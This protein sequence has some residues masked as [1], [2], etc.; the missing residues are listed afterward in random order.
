MLSG[1]VGRSDGD[2]GEV[3]SL[4]DYHRNTVARRARAGGA[5]TSRDINIVPVINHW[6]DE[7]N[8]THLGLNLSR[9]LTDC[10]GEA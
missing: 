9:R 6:S 5:L 10:L 3:C 1:N 2:G 8:K 4:R 7:P